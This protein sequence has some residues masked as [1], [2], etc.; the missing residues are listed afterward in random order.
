VRGI[1]YDQRGNTPKDTNPGFIPFG[2]AG[3]IVDRDTGLIRFGAR[4]YD[5]SIGRW[6]QKDAIGFNGGLNFYSYAGGDPINQVDPS[7][8]FFWIAVGAA[9]GGSADLAW[10]LAGNGGNL[11]CVDWW[12]VGGAALLGA[13]AGYFAGEALAAEA[14]DTGLADMGP[15]KVGDRVFR[16]FGDQNNPLGQSWTRIDPRSVGDFR[17]VAG[18]PDRN[19]GTNIIEGVLKDVTGVTN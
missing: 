16:V 15:P 9:V 14:A 4:D 5:P 18:L 2:F 10:Q 12:Q 8:N 19:L 6:T 1:P 11:S 3:G 7:G 13:G 17:D